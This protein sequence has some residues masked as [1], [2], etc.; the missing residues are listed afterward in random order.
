MSD[1]L[2]KFQCTSPYI[3]KAIQIMSLKNLSSGV[4]F[5]QDL[6]SAKGT[7]IQRGIAIRLLRVV[8]LICLD[9]IALTLAWKL[10]VFYGTPLESPWTQ[11]TSFLLLILT[12]E[13]GIIGAQ[14]LYQAGTH[15]RN[16]FRLLKAVSLSDVFFVVIAFLYEPNH[17]VS[18]SILLLF[19]LWSIVF[20]CTGRILFDL[21]TKFLRKKGAIRYPVFLIADREEQ[22]G[23]ISLLE[24]ENCYTVQGVSES[25][26]LDRANREATLESL[27][28]QG[29]VEAFVS[30]N[31][32]KN[33]LYVCWHFQTAGI[34]LRILPTAGVVRYPKTMLWM[35]GIGEVPCLTIS[36]PI[37]LRVVLFG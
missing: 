21:I 7:R 3:P 26:C 13:I 37:V 31:A 35:T 28:K 8:T 12:V 4:N 17:Y 16:Y 29:V 34:L 14:G 24:Q 22:E 11:K 36:S 1:D 6:R 10:A 32:I 33:R 25:I 19:W 15:R 30:W 23:H 2:L 18:R 27:R 5:Q 9:I 20:I